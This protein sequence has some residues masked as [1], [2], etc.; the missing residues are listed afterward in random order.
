MSEITFPSGRF[1]EAGASD[2]ELS[3]LEREFSHSD[4]GV[5]SSLANHLASISAGDLREY[6][7]DLR[8]IGHFQTSEPV[9]GAEESM[10]ASDD[11]G[12]ASG[13][14]DDESVENVAADENEGAAP[15][16]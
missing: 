16:E 3:Q 5:Q 13:A 14:T 7:A 6:L 9:D 1:A 4:I 10:A 15:G 12:S 8:E 2:A 11:P